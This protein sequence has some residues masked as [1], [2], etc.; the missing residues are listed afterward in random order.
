MRN[1][2]TAVTSMCGTGPG[3][4]DFVGLRGRIPW[5]S[6]RSL[7]LRPDG[8]VPSKEGHGRKWR[9]RMCTTTAVKAPDKTLLKGEERVWNAFENCTAGQ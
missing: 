7:A 5:P 3:K 1:P 4:R 9:N 8:L 6:N 2:P